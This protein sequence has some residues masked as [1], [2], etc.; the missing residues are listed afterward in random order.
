MR[1][2]LLVFAG[3]VGLLAA[4][5]GWQRDWIVGWWHVRQLAAADGPGREEAVARVL[6]V[7]DPSGWLLRHLAD[8]D[9]R[10]AANLQAGLVALAHEWTADDPR[11][12]RLAEQL[13]RRFE[14][15]G[16]NGKPALLLAAAALLRGE[17]TPSAETSQA[18]GDLLM[19][20]KPDPALASPALRLAASLA[21]RSPPGQWLDALREMAR[22]GLGSAEPEGRVAA[23]HL[24]LREP[25]RKQDD[26]LRQIVPLVRDADAAVRKAAVVA[27]GAQPNLLGE[28]DL[29]P[30]LHDPDAEVQVVTE[31]ALR[32]RGL[33]DDHLQLARWISDQR[34]QARMQVLHHLRRTA[35]LEPGV[36]LRRLMADPTPAVRA[37][38]VRAS[39]DQLSPELA[40][41]LRELSRHDSSPTVRELAGYYLKER[42]R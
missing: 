27:L 28:D 13:P 40:D 20:A 38:A 16:R 42:P 5:G 22:S 18:L 29:L 19:A 31:L 39:S 34:P 26:L 15:C 10:A 23:I 32:S 35:D 17:K 12:R 14:T 3:I 36:W 6:S 4:V 7:D 1:R 37:A 33:D 8:A 24:V 9:P 11:G 2:K 30:L 21:E 25:L 41:Q